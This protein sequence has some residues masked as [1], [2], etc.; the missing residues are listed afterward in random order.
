MAVTRSGDGGGD[1]L[2]QMQRDDLARLELDGS[3]SG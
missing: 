2:A 1:R 3:K